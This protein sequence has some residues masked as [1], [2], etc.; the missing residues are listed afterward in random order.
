M[1]TLIFFAGIALFGVWC[2]FNLTP[3]HLRKRRKSVE[4]DTIIPE[5]VATKDLPFKFL[6]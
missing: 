6:R 5:A 2:H 1:E 3:Y 4:G